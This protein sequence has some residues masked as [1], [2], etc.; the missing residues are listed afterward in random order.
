M[1]KKGWLLVQNGVET[2]FGLL[3]HAIR[4]KPFTKLGLV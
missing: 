1:H 3:I 2:G 4:K